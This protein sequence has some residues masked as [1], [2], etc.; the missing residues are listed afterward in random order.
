[1]REERS[2]VNVSVAS[3]LIPLLGFVLVILKAAG[4]QPVADWSWWIVTMPFWLGLSVTL[5]FLALFLLGAAIVASIGLWLQ[6]RE[7]KK[8]RK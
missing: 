7:E 2:S 8:W 5:A 6:K 1:M 3:G 4:V